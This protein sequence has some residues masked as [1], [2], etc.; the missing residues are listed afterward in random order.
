MTPQKTSHAPDSC[1]LRSL[2]YISE[3][4]LIGSRQDVDML[5]LQA[6]AFGFRLDAQQ[7][8]QL[9][10]NI[11]RT[12]RYNFETAGVA[13]RTDLKYDNFAVIPNKVE[14]LFQVETSVDLLIITLPRD[15][16]RIVARNY[17]L[18]GFPDPRLMVEGLHDP[19]VG[20]LVGELWFGE[21]LSISGSPLYE[22]G[23]LLTLCSRILSLWTRPMVEFAERTKGLSNSEFEA[24]QNYISAHIA[25]NMRVGDLAALVGR[26]STEFARAFKSATGVPPY[27]WVIE[28]RLD[29]ATH[30]LR[31]SDMSLAEIAYTCGFSSQARMTTIFSERRGAT[32]GQ[33][34][35]RL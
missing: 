15:L 22:E 18:V 13:G 33:L 30:L 4:R 32:P 1:S 9:V 12:A 26:S 21:R 3:H 24:V 17:S 34:R 16:F 23:V 20:R 6:P 11:G 27:Q 35:R 5:R 8:S 7:D 14:I 28:R 19:V 29:R 31:R 10:F 25:E 2:E